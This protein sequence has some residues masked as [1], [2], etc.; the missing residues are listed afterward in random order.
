[1][2]HEGQQYVEPL[3]YATLPPEAVKKV[4]VLLRSVTYGDKKLME[5]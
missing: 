3:S 4:E 2:T 1:M 5:K